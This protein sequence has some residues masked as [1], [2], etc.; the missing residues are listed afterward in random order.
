MRTTIELK[1]DYRGRLLAL[2]A[3]RGEK[4]FSKIIG[5]AVEM[6]LK[7]VVADEERRDLA[8]VLRGRMGKKEAEELRR[9]T[10]E[11]RESWR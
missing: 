4:G 8:L 6:Y 10:T 3:S 1:D 2:A 7:S 11:L 5:E 9:A